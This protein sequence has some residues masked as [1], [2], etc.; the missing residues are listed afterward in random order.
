MK[1]AATA[2]KHRQYDSIATITKDWN[3]RTAY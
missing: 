2:E 3:A 1:S